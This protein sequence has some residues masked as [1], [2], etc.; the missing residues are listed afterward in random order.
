MV[1]RIFKMNATNGFV[2]ALK[3]TKF[4]FGQGSAL[5]PAGEALPLGG[6]YSAP[7]DLLVG[8][9]GPTSKGRGEEGEG[10]GRGKGK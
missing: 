7:R 4:V 2:T 3:R 10:K 9:K 5:D 1:L 6:T 8:L